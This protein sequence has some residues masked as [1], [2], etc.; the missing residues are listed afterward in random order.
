MGHDEAWTMAERCPIRV[1]G[2]LSVGGYK[3][4]HVCG[5]VWLGHN[6]VSTVLYLSSA[7]HTVDVSPLLISHRQIV[8]NSNPRRVTHI[9]RIIQE[10]VF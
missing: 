10:D 6:W 3:C 1:G 7:V 9:V 8:Y 5:C 2:Y 4:T